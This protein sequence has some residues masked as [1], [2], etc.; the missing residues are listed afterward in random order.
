MGF[1]PVRRGARRFFF[2]DVRPE[3]KF[4]ITE[5]RVLLVRDSANIADTPAE[6]RPRA[7]VAWEPFTV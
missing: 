6:N 2:A 3:D 4:S 5:R 1:L 7:V